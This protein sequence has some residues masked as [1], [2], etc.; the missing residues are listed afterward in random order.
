MDESEEER[1]GGVYSFFLFMAY[2]GRREREGKVTRSRDGTEA[3]IHGRYDRHRTMLKE[4]QL[5]EDEGK[6]EEMMMS[7]LLRL[8]FRN[9]SVYVLS[10]SLSPLC[11]W[12]FCVFCVRH[13]KH[14]KTRAMGWDTSYY[15]YCYFYF[16]LSLR[17]GMGPFVRHEETKH[18]RETGAKG[19]E[20]GYSF[21]A[22]WLGF[23]A[24]GSY[25]A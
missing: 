3:K 7:I 13:G 8:Y 22:C 18:A 2:M 1:T 12:T 16:F 5:W 14:G 19:R 9:G 20:E 15:Y 4:K 17:F 10:V 6:G 11:M 23:S 25:D 21:H 24:C